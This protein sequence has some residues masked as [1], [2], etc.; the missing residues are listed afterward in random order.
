MNKT[1]LAP[2]LQQKLICEFLESMV[3]V[4]AALVLINCFVFSMQVLGILLPV[5]LF[6][7]VSSRR[8]QPKKQA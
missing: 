8:N 2:S 4:I 1:L 5:I 6:S 3:L 7:V